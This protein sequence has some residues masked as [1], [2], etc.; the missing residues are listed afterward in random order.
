MNACFGRLSSFLL[1][2]TVAQ[3]R[4]WLGPHKGNLR[5]ALSVHAF[6]FA[7][8][9]YRIER[10]WFTPMLPA[11]FP[12]IIRCS[13]A[14]ARSDSRKRQMRRWPSPNGYAG[15][16]PLRANSKSCLGFMDRNFAATN[17]STNR[18]GSRAL[19]ATGG[20]ERSSTSLLGCIEPP[21]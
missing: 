2:S 3:A 14:F 1:L 20:D 12:W 18:S 21:L 15:I 16:V 13:I 4:S 19:L 6:S 10:G 5:P 17:E 11:P 8:L 7:L 9:P